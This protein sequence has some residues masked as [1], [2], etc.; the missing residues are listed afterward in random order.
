MVFFMFG[1]YVPAPPADSQVATGAPTFQP[2]VAW[3]KGFS[4]GKKHAK[5]LNPWDDIKIYF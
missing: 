3:K 2:S 5:E 1:S 4:S